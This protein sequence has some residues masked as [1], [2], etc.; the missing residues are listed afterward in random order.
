MCNSD[1]AGEK[2]YQEWTQESCHNMRSKCLAQIWLM[3]ETISVFYTTASISEGLELSH[4][5]L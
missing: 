1:N 4:I 2:W 3:K 5:V